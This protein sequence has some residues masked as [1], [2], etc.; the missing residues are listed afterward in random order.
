MD[1]FPPDWRPDVMTMGQHGVRR[2][3]L[4]ASPLGKRNGVIYRAIC[5]S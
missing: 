3:G 4:V 1:D 2:L 5:A